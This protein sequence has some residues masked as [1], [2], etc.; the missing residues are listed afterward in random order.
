[1]S[2]L[3]DKFIT[4]FKK[5]ISEE[6]AAMRQRLGPF[7]VELTNGRFIENRGDGT[8][9]HAF[10][11]VTPNDKLILHSECTFNGGGVEFLVTVSALSD[12]TVTLEGEHLLPCSAT[13][14]RLVIYPWFLY[15]RLQ[16]TLSKMT[17]MSHY[18]IK[19]A[20]RLFGKESPAVDE[21]VSAG[22]VTSLNKGQNKAINL[23]TKSNLAFVWGP[24]GTG[25]T[26]TLAHIVLS[27]LAQGQRLLVTS[28]TNAAVD[29]VLAKL[30]SINEGKSL[31]TDG[32]I[33]RVGFTD[34]PTF[35]ASLRDVARR[36]DEKNQSLLE[37]LL[38]QRPIF[39]KK[40]KSCQELLSMLKAGSGPRQLSL[41]GPPQSETLSARDLATV[42]GRERTKSLLRL[43]EQE[44]SNSIKLRQRRLEA[45]LELSLEKIRAARA[46]LRNQEEVALGQAKVVLATMT[47]MY[48]NKLLSKERFD[49]VIVEE[50]GMAILPTLF[51]CSSL[52]KKKTIMIGDPRQLPPI[53]QSSADYVR[54]AMGR[55]IFEVTVPNPHE[56]KIV[57]MLSTQYRMHPVI[58]KLVSKLF[59]DGKLEND[60]CT[61]DRQSIADCPPFPNEPLILLDTRGMGSCQTREGAYSRFNEETAKLCVSLASHAIDG[62]LNSV[63]IIAPYA[64]HIRVVNRL[65]TQTLSRD[66]RD[67]I[68]CRTVHRFQG[69][70]RDLVIFDT[71]DTVPLKPGILLSDKRPGSSA[72][73]L[74]NV[75]ISR[76]RGKLV[77]VS[78]AAYFTSRAPQSIIDELTTVVREKGV[79]R[80]EL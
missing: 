12:K 58:G 64:E 33:V 27:Q 21:K 19:A 78:D 62:G 67:K 18:N 70:E 71:V 51:Y 72:R 59:Y 28:T 42:F 76:A 39:E 7:E 5:A 38:R 63:A 35:G 69:N 75:S 9:L 16:E 61:R 57:A 48:I 80:S 22:I 15:E 65:L 17:E 50:A 43:T 40:A 13:D 26:T 66:K 56:S 14:A 36:Q 60:D 4:S 46:T 34:S 25:K 23:C 37:R 54:K 44:Q 32:T 8:Q 53:V 55:S 3:L 77:I 29:Q 6:M 24:P 10:D 41:F 30:S 2:K 79:Q 74:V 45:A 31:L 68:E 73:N 1:M 47:N 52:A 20:M 49:V 11:I